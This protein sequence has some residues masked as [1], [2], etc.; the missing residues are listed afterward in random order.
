MLTTVV[1]SFNADNKFTMEALSRVEAAGIPLISSLNN[2]T[3]QIVTMF[4]LSS[5]SSLDLITVLKIWSSCGEKAPPTWRN[6][7]Q[8]IRQLHLDDLAQQ[9]EAYLCGGTLK[10]FVGEGMR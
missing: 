4:D 8:V 7:L 2:Y 3:Q 9:V 5:L 10:K 6:L 1:T